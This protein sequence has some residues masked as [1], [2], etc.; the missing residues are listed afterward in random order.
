MQASSDMS[1]IDFDIPYSI[2]F[3]LAAGIESVA[4]ILIM[5]TVTWQVLV[6]AIPVV[7]MVVFVQVSAG[8]LLCT[9]LNYFP[10]F[11]S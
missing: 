1:V 5:A 4:I 3:V 11:R 6:V 8:N 2:A 9:P 7:I 10:M